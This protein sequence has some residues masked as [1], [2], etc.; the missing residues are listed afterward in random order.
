VEH[1]RDRKNEYIDCLE[2]GWEGELERYEKEKKWDVKIVD[3]FPLM[4]SDWLG[5]AIMVLEFRDDKILSESVFNR[6][7]GE[8]IV[9]G[10]KNGHYWRLVLEEKG[11]K[12]EIRKDYRKPTIVL[13]SV[14]VEVDNKIRRIFNN[15]MKECNV[16]FRSKRLYDLTKSQSKREREVDER[17]EKGV[18][19]EFECRE[20]E[21]EGKEVKYIGETGRRLKERV[22]EHMR[23]SNEEKWTEVGR[24]GMEMHGKVDEGMWR[25]KVL[26]RERDE[27]RRRVVEA[28][29]IEKIKPE[30]NKSKGVKVIGMKWM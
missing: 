13:P 6:G 12:D 15:E 30:L 20:C 23:I 16:C 27:F 14:S 4:M 17:E 8:G 10:L 24:H 2:E 11:K 5:R 7:K 28:V 25:I 26:E 19:Y 3:L 9:I 22:K 21:R 1:V 18:V 29:K